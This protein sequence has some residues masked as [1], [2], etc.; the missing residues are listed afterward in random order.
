LLKG[1]KRNGTPNY[2]LGMYFKEGT[3]RHMKAFHGGREAKEFLITKIVAEAQEENIALSEIERKM[4]Y[5]T[6]SGWTLPDIMKVSEDFDGEYDQDKYEQKIA[7]LVTKADRRIRKGSREEYDTWWAAI[8]FLQREDHYILVMIRRAGLRPRGDQ[9]RLFGAGL[10]IATCMLIWGFLSIKYNIPVPSRG[11][12]G[13]FV[14]AVFA[15]LFIA[16]MLLRFILGSRRTDELTSKVL[17][18]LVRIYQRVAG[19][20]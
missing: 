19:T 11:D 18:K 8:R 13:T 12:F 20:A 17:E 5:F 15:C 16:Y 3:I 14:W 9:L 2:T 6:E 4:L 1:A 7:K 10:G